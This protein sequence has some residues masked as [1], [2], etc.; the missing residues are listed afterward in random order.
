MSTSIEQHVCLQVSPG[1]LFF[2][3][4]AESRRKEKEI[5]SQLMSKMEELGISFSDIESGWCG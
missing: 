1:G 4:Y 2:I 5:V 3:A